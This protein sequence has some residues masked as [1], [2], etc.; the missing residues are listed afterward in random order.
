[1]LTTGGDQV[2]VIGVAFVEVVGRDGAAVPTQIGVGVLKIGAVWGFTVTSIVVEI[3]HCVI[4]GVK[5]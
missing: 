1:M 5:V 4:S 2:P 3:A